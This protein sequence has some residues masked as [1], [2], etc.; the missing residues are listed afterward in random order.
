L[1]EYVATQYRPNGMRNNKHGMEKVGTIPNTVNMMLCSVHQ[2]VM[3][4]FPSWPQKV[5]ARFAN[6]RQFGAFLVASS[7]K[8]GEVQYVKV[9]SEKGRPCTLVNP[10]SGKSI[11]V[12]RDGKQID[13]LRGDRVILKTEAG[14]TVLLGPEG[15]GL[16]NEK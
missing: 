2:D 9:Y 1:H 12:Y 4:L 14:T 13:T 8:G 3:R 11:N 10:W 7:L 16:P 15:A 6:L 5:D